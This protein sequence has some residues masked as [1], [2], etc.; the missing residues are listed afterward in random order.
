MSYKIWG[1]VF[2]LKKVKINFGSRIDFYDK[3]KEW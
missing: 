3:I 1:Y 2:G